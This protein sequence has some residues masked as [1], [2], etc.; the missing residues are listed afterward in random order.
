MEIGEVYTVSEAV[1][2]TDAPLI[3]VPTAVS[4]GVGDSSEHEKEMFARFQD[5]DIGEVT[6]EGGFERGVTYV[7]EAKGQTT[8]VL[9]PIAMTTAPCGSAGDTAEERFDA[10]RECLIELAFRTTSRIWA[11][12]ANIINIAGDAMSADCLKAIGEVARMAMCHRA[13]SGS[14]NQ[15]GD[16][17]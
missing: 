8:T 6:D 1:A 7:W 3:A 14:G 5:M 12:P 4:V 2:G 17:Q 10:L 11:M 15:T 16:D 13:P 9:L